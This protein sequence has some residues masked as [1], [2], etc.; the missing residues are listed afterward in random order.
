MPT[1][2]SGLSATTTVWTLAVSHYIR[3]LHERNHSLLRHIGLLASERLSQRKN[4]IG[5]FRHD[6]WYGLGVFSS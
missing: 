5:K 6:L 1:C 4:M 2:S 3:Q